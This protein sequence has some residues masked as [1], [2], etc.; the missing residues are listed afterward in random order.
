[1]NIFVHDEHKY[2]NRKR[3]L[4]ALGIIYPHIKLCASHHHI[5]FFSC[6][7]INIELYKRNQEKKYIYLYAYQEVGVR[8][9]ETSIVIRVNMD[10]GKLI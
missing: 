6:L 8:W 2:R 5:Y 9:G 10:S 7:F 4:Q 3:E 1:M